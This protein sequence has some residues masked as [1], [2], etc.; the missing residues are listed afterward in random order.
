[1]AKISLKKFVFTNRDYVL[2]MHVEA[3]YKL[4]GRRRRTVRALKRP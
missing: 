3:R 2:I 4:I 1:M